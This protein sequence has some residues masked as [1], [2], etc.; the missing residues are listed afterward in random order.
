MLWYR[1]FHLLYKTMSFHMNY[2]LQ[3]NVNKSISKINAWH[4]V[5]LSSRWCDYY[6]KWTYKHSITLIVSAFLIFMGFLFLLSY[7]SLDGPDIYPASNVTS[8]HLH[9]PLFELMLQGWKLSS[10]DEERDRWLAYINCSRQ[11]IIRRIPS[12]Q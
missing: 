11:E 5:W 1:I 4:R 8:N 12:V 10:L 6:D 2:D 3:V 7:G 9:F